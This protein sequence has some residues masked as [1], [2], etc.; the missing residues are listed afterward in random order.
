MIFCVINT[1]ALARDADR[2]SSGGRPYSERAWLLKNVIL[3][4]YHSLRVFD[5]IIV[6]GEYE[7]GPYHRYVPCPQTR[8][9]ETDPLVM[10]DAGFRAT[11]GEK[12]D[13]IL[14]Q[15]D[16][17]LWSPDNRGYTG[18]DVPVCSPSRRDADGPLADGGQEYVNGHVLVMRRWVAEQVPWVSAGFVHAWDV[19][20][21]KRLAE[22]G[23]PWKYI[24]ELVALDVEPFATHGNQLEYLKAPDGVVPL[25]RYLPG[26]TEPWTAD[27]V[28]G[29]ARALHP[30]FVVETGTF[31]G[32]TTLALW[33]ALREQDHLSVLV[34]VEMDHDRCV[35]A[36]E[37]LRSAAASRQGRG[38]CSLKCQEGD[39]IA[40]LRSLPSES[41]DL[42]FLDD[43]H[44]LDHVAVEMME[45]LRVLRSHGVL[46][47]HDVSG[48]SP[49]GTLVKT[50]GGVVLDFRK[51]HH[52]GG[53]GIVVKP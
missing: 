45:A 23:I 53:L 20:Y 41:V 44:T 28:C 39:A 51:M 32:R 5:E 43:D 37:A 49:L 8:H 9:N 35:T 52:T 22:Q 17:H 13:W 6:V 21:T 12:D 14:F 16:D 29:I 7:E 46:C 10:R 26:S 34:S 19:G 4:W 38:S 36:A 25:E 11:S 18:E 50:M 48:A 1:I 40:Y 47:M 42:V 31:E 30:S 27:V 3:P 15:H 33:D 2:I 24:P